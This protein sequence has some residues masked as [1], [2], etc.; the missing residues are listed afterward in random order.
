VKTYTHH[1]WRVSLRRAHKQRLHP[2]HARIIAD[3]CARNIRDS[4]ARVDDQ[5]RPKEIDGRHVVVEHQWH[6]ECARHSRSV[7][8][9]RSIMV[10]VVMT[11]WEYFVGPSI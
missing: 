3:I 5:T 11:G 7:D 6:H 2:H 1:L 9:D 10:A 8:M 4:S